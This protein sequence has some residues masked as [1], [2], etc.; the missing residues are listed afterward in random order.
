MTKQEMTS[1]LAK[2]GYSPFLQTVV[3][4]LVNAQTLVCKAGSKP[5]VFILYRKDTDEVVHFRNL[6]REEEKP[7]DILAFVED[8]RDSLFLPAETA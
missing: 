4:S 6:P 7:A 1:A 8:F 3:G 2:E 5:L